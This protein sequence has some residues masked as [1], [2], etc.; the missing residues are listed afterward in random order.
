MVDRSFKRDSPNSEFQ[1]ILTE[2]IECYKNILSRVPL[3]WKSHEFYFHFPSLKLLSKFLKKCD[4]E[5]IEKSWKFLLKNGCA[6]CVFILN[7][8]TTERN[9][10]HRFRII[11]S[12]KVWKWY[13]PQGVR[14]WYSFTQNNAAIP[15]VSV[16]DILKYWL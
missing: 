12:W 14:T 11:W 5:I 13:C 8:C 7:L 1:Y 9:S 16:P 3:A 15:P 10:G 2:Y 6:H 4:S